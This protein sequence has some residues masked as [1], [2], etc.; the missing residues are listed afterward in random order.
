MC[1]MVMISTCLYSE[2]MDGMV[3]DFTFCSSQALPELLKNIKK[4]ED[5]VNSS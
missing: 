2:A 3:H 1:L 5:F 4:G